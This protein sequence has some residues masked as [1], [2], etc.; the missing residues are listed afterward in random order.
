SLRELTKDTR[1]L[2]LLDELAAL[3]PWRSLM[4][5]PSQWA[6]RLT[7]IAGESPAAFEAGMNEAAE[8]LGDSRRVSIEEFWSAAEAVLRLSP[9]RIPD[10][11]R[12]V[13]H[14]LSVYEARQWELPIVFICGLAEQQFPK[15]HAQEPFFPDS[16]RQRL[17][18]SGIRVRTAAELERE[19]RFLF[20]L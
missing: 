3:N 7:G 8:F 19:E 17:A 14:V 13:V 18:Q 2:R 6:I 11:R 5:I 4:L 20:E 1:V 12:N 16:A 15:R 10:R 9:L